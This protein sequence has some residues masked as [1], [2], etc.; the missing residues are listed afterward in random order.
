[1]CCAHQPTKDSLELT[2]T[3]AA[4]LNPV[5]HT[6]TPPPHTQTRHECGKGLWGGERTEVVERAEDVDGDSGQSAFC[7]CSKLRTNLTYKN[8]IQKNEEGTRI[9][10]N[11]MLMDWTN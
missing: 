1:M 3:Q 4:C 7:T 6:P 10:E 2:V 9:G 11:F 5:G 8:T